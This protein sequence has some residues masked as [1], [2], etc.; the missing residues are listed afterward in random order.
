[1]AFSILIVNN[2]K[3]LRTLTSTTIRDMGF[4][5]V[6][7]VAD[8]A[9]AETFVEIVT[10]D[11][12]IILELGPRGNHL[13]ELEF[14]KKLEDYQLEKKIRMIITSEVVDQDIY[15]KFNPYGVDEFIQ[16]TFVLKEFSR[17]LEDSIG[18]LSRQITA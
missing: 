10:D 15:E 12:I 5:N 7:Q 6:K 1:M 8:L 13:E 14:V 4:E 2:V 17:K 3:S 16:Q 11:I 18:E 9:D